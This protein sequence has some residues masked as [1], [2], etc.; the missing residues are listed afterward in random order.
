MQESR[1]RKF[2]LIHKKKIK[3]SGGGGKGGGGGGRIPTE[4]RDTLRSRAYAQVVDLVS[5]GE[6]EGLVDGNKSIFFDETPLENEDGSANF[7]GVTIETRNGTQE[8]T[9]LP[10]FT[11]VEND[12]SVVVEVRKD[13]PVTRR[14]T[15]SDVT[16]VR[17]RLLVPQ[18]TNQSAETGDVNGA[19]IAFKIEVQ[20]NG[21][22][23]VTVID[24]SDGSGEE[25]SGKTTGRYQ[26]TYRLGLNTTA[27]WDIRVTRL[28]NDA[29]HVNVQDKLYFDAYTEIIDAKLRYP[30]SAYIGIK[31]DASQFAQI[32][33]RGYDLKGIKIRIPDNATVR[34]DGSLTYSGTWAGTFQTAWCANPAWV[35]FD[36]LTSTR[37]GLGNYLPEDQV[38]KWSF[39][40][41]GVYCDSLVDDGDGGTEPRFTAN[42]YIQSQEEAFKVIQDLSSIFRAMSYWSAGSVFVAQD[43]PSDPV[44]LFTQANVIEGAFSYAGS[45]ARV[46]HSVALVTW[47]D[48][49]DFYRQKVEYVEDADAIV[50]Y[51]IVTTQVVAVGCTSRGQA[52][53]VGRWILYSEQNETET[54][55]FRTGIEGAVA[56]PGNIIKVADI[57][58]AGT[59]M[60]GRIADATTTTVTV[61]SDIDSVDTGGW[62]LSV[63]LD[64]GTL[65]T[66]TVSGNVGRVV[67]VSSAFSSAPQAQNI[68][69]LS[70]SDVEPQLF[71][72]L[73]V[74]EN[75]EGTFDITALAHSAEKYAAVENGMQ[76]PER[77][78][79]I[80]SAIPDT[81]EDVV[82]TESL[83]SSN[84]L[85]RTKVTISWTTVEG[86]GSYSV[87]YRRENGNWTIIPELFQNSVDV[88]DIE[89]DT[90]DFQVS[91]INS[92]G[93]KSIPASLS[94]ILYGKTALPENVSNFSVFPNGGAA[95]LTWTKS[96][97][98]D[99]QVGGFVRIRHTP[100]T[101]G[102]TWGSS[103]DVIDFVPGSD[104]FATAPLL[105]GTYMA[106]FVD[107]S[108]N[109]SE[110]ETLAVTSIPVPVG[111][112]VVSTQT[113]TGVFGGTHSNTGFVTDLGL[114]LLSETL[115]DDLGPVDDLTSV[116]FGSDVLG[117]GE[118]TFLNTVD[119][120]SIFTSNLTAYIKTL[121]FDTGSNWDDVLESIDDWTDI[122]GSNVAAVNAKLYVRTTTDNPS[123]SP[124]WT[125]WKPFLT[126]SYLA[127][128][129][130]FK[131]LLT[132]SLATENIAVQE[133]SVTI[134]M[135]DRVENHMALSSGL[136]DP[137][138]CAFDK[139]FNAIPA[140][141]ITTHNLSTG[142]YFT[143]TNKAT[144]GF[145]IVFK[146]SAGTVV[147]RI[148]DYVVKGYGLKG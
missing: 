140:V 9:Y 82:A 143:V 124:T 113:E 83:F 109:E 60:G 7:T 105:A 107:S 18:L 131:I 31:I 41:T 15:D 64:D 32:P 138:H 50:R 67:T 76:L 25:I 126:G 139:E 77:S 47:N 88:L 119:L 61:D 91:S 40:T 95:F 72:V 102:Q 16:A 141:G 122:D 133:L 57:M 33:R 10:G 58:R 59:R 62:E 134:D 14:I 125:E 137:Y 111:L 103:I 26:R 63:M 34:A 78:I 114:V 54:V 73:S 23:Y 97:A 21:G 45:S 120:G 13:S 117:S 135:P 8:Q 144:S 106:K 145:D 68:F 48:P 65:E 110:T 123:G 98:L 74:V 90:Y 132:S 69:M 89:P 43:S 142:D 3:G 44:Y 100:R 101:S 28:T 99:V 5:E 93:R 130:Q 4:A 36:L 115:W 148:F 37:Y 39:Y 24:G 147:S 116:D 17:V 51:G 146:N 1:L 49:D 85:V 42:L 128:G 80:L 108:G 11:T 96:V 35:L 19:K 38:D 121:A 84:G 27:P 46:R 112:N 29:T 86:A 2:Q 94:T 55:S 71:R 127:R 79:S 70:S 75:I 104:T 136:V 12:I 66:K 52:N 22:G 87:K 56:R 129:Y 118:Y 30:N 20:S 6:I 81:P 53:R 92:I